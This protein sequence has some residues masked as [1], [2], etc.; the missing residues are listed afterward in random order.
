M[1]PVQIRRAVLED[2]PR[3]VALMHGGSVTAPVEQLGPPLPAAYEAAFRAIQGSAYFSVWVAEV[4]G[5]V[6]GTFQFSAM[7]NLSNVGRPVAQVESVHVAAARRGQ[8]VGAVMMQWAIAEA[9]R[10]GCFRLQLT[11]NK[12]REDA[13]RFYRRL[14]FVD[15][16]LGMK[17]KL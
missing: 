10:L 16:H 12:L 8:G 1:E 15:S 17:L 6:V 13:H 11:S 4:A 14:G 2:L 5:E 9:R 7:P 3:I